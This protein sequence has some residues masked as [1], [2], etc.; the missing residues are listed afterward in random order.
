MTKTVAYRHKLSTGVNF[1]DGQNTF[2]IPYQGG[3]VQADFNTT[4]GANLLIIE[5]NAFRKQP[6]ILQ[7]EGDTFLLTFGASEITVTWKH[8]ALSI[9]DTDDL[10]FTFGL[11]GNVTITEPVPGDADHFVVVNPTGTGFDFLE[12]TNL[13]ELN[14]LVGAADKIPY[15]DG[16][17]SMTLANFTATG[18][19]LVGAASADAAM[20][21][22]GFS[23]FFKTLVGLTTA[24]AF[25]T[26]IALGASDTVHFNKLG[27]GAA[28]TDGVV[29]IQAGTAGAVAAPTDAHLV[30]E[31]SGAAYASFLAGTAS[32]A[33]VIIGD[34]GDNDIASLLYDNNTNA[35]QLIGNTANLLKFDS[36]TN[37]LHRTT[38]ATYQ[39]VFGGTYRTFEATGGTQGYGIFIGDADNNTVFQA[40]TDDIT[41]RVVLGA[42]TNHYVEFNSNNINRGVITAAGDWVFGETQ[43]TSSN[44]GRLTLRRD[45]ATARDAA[46][47]T[48][49]GVLA[50]RNA[51]T[52]NVANRNV[53][54]FGSVGGSDEGALAWVH[55]SSTNSTNR[56]GWEMSGRWDGTRTLGFVVQG[57]GQVFVPGISTTAG[58]GSGMRVDNAAGNQ[59]L[60]DTSSLRYKTDVED[61]LP[62][63]SSRI[64]DLRPIWFR[65]TASADNP[66]WSWWGLGAEEVAAIDTR[67]VDYGFHDDDYE[68]IATPDVHLF[69][70]YDNSG[71]FIKAGTQKLD[72]DGTKLMVYQR[73][74]KPGAVP[75]VIGVKYDRVS[76]LMLAEMQRLRREVD[77]LQTE[78]TALKAA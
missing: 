19:N 12:G 51:D 26:G 25:A 29:H 18:R 35:W 14:G 21:A 24:A 28:W 78:L 34:S 49:N 48:W 53:T 57:D 16:V 73:V 11:L 55:K 3:D 68:M 22:L 45:S 75:S 54:I 42:R 77:V 32:A 63:Y 76:I 37:M 6:V 33:G 50:L 30:I 43:T 58:G 2:T 67:L 41:G 74:R 13:W 70:T 17:G 36:T 20:T 1:R 15:F 59:L 10:L 39:A 46:A 7:D 72:T 38:T 69:D 52:S 44:G 47:G 4:A 62:E 64:Y 31:H 66:A 5:A 27:V 40:W 9:G 56:G 60:R 8:P 61:I 23:T 71:A 65:S